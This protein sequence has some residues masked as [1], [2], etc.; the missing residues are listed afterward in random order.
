VVALPGPVA[1]GGQ[2]WRCPCGGHLLQDG[3]GFGTLR[4]DEYGAPGLDDPSLLGRDL[5]EGVSQD[6]RVIEADGGDHRHLGLDDVGGVQA[7]A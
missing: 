6:R 1:A 7:P 5:R 3:Q 4:G 2:E